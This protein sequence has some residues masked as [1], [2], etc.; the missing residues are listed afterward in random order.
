VTSKV[1]LGIAQISAEPNEVEH[2]KALCRQAILDCFSAMADLVVLP[3]LI[4]QG[5]VTD[6]GRL[7]PIAETIPGPTVE[8]WT[9]LAASSN[10]YVVGGLVERSDDRLYNSAV[11]IGPQGLIAHYRKVHLFAGEKQT[12]TPGDLGFP[13]ALTRFGTIGVCVCYDLRFVEVTRILSLRGAEVIC[14]PSA[15]VPGFDQTRW[16]DSGMAPQARTAE[17]LANLNQVYIACASQAGRHGGQEFLGSS[18]VIDPYGRRSLGPMSGTS[19]QIETVVVDLGDS[20]RSQF[21]GT[22]ISPRADRRRDVYG[23][24]VGEDVL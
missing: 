14:V 4:V 11:A 22:G 23:I 24:K 15:W 21:R 18:V 8:E 3:E 6:R 7:L 19:D 10:G 5:Y 20:A 2:N 16:D 12:F 9:E 17:V 1:G 13:T